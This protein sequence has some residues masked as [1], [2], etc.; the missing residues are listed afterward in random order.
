MTQHMTQ[1]NDTFVSWA[2]GPDRTVELPAISVPVYLIGCE[3][4]DIT[5][6]WIIWA[7]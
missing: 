5:G 6:G 2:D 7:E 3:H 4:E 1:G